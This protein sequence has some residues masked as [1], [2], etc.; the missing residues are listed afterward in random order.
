MKKVLFLVQL[1]P[2]IHG[3]SIVNETIYKSRIISGEYQTKFI[4]ITTS[5]N[6]DEIGRVGFKKLFVSLNLCKKIITTY[7]NLKPDL[8]YI[9]LSPVGF[10][11]LKDSL[12]LI[13]IK[14]LGGNIAIHLHGK[15]IRG[16][17]EESKFWFIFYRLILKKVHIIHLS[18]ILFNDINNVR[19]KNYQLIAIPNGIDLPKDLPTQKKKVFTFIYLSNLVPGK[20]VDILINASHLIPDDIRSNYQIKIFGSFSDSSYKEKI[21]KLLENKKSNN[22]KLCGPI[23]GI[24]KFYEL[25]SSMAFVLPT[26]YKNECF[27]LSILEAMGA[28]IPII[29][30]NEGAIAEIVDN[31]ECGQVIDNLSPENLSKALIRY[32][33]DP[34]LAALHG[35]TAKR[36]FE[37]YYKVEIFEKNLIKYLN[38]L[39]VNN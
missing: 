19:D 8:V 7:I 26:R 38:K 29:S 25:S 23:Y 6:I 15:G 4:N 20:G 32:I 34:E 1:P 31:N 21:Y 28:G 27:P 14:I 16:Y 9:T 24:K 17:T 39:I 35:K 12:F 2:P 37:N 33:N 11:F 3:A 36:K 18:Q 30:S 22:I 13:L 5:K 10:A